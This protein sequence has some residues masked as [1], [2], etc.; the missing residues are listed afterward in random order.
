MSGIEF[1]WDSRDLEVFRGGKVEKAALEVEKKK[2]ERGLMLEKFQVA[3]LRTV[4]GM[5]K[6]TKDAPRD[7]LVAE[8]RPKEGKA[9]LA[10]LLLREKLAIDKTNG[11]TVRVRTPDNKDW[12]TG[13]GP[14]GFALPKD[15]ALGVLR[16]QYADMFQGDGASGAGAIR[17]CA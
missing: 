14:D 1:V 7:A 4:D 5:G 9:E 15:Y 6:G 13:A 2:T 3:L 11:R 8:M 12:M 16:T 17:S 10:R